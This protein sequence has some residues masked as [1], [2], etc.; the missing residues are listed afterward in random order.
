MYEY[1]LPNTIPYS[2]LLSLVTERKCDKYI[3]YHKNYVNELSSHKFVLSI[4]M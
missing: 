4:E 1:T 3:N 2:L